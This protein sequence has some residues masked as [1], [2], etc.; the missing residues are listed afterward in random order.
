MKKDRRKTKNAAA[1]N[2]LILVQT[3]PMV[4]AQF[5]IVAEESQ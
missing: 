4:T 2:P 5:E 3:K 1:L